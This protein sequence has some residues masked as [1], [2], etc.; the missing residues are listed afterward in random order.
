MLYVIPMRRSFPI[1]ISIC[2]NLLQH[3]RKLVIYFRKNTPLRRQV[4]VPETTS[5]CHLKPLPRGF[6]DLLT[7]FR[8]AWLTPLQKE[9]N[10]LKLDQNGWQFAHIFKCIFLKEYFYILIGISL[11]FVPRVP[12]EKR[13]QLVQIMAW[14]PTGY[15]PSPEPMIN[16]PS[17]FLQAWMC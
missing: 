8:K 7:K 9:V 1:E 5:T 15:N 6:Q 16:Q 14:C 4:S 10:T 17:M 2:H 13:P 3:V 11:K 12:I